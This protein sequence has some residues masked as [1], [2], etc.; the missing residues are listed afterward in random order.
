MD[1][2]QHYS[3]EEDTLS[4]DEEDAILITLALNAQQQLQ[5][6]QRKVWVHNLNIK[7]PDVGQYHT[8]IDDLRLDEGKF[9]GYFRMSI[10]SFDELLLMLTPYIKKQD[11]N[12]RKAIC[13]EQ[14]LAI[15]LR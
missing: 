2:D 5:R 9:F 12:M 3:S 11:T 6:K 15:T 8:I 13:P 7:R 10:N 1:Q 4:S 14:R